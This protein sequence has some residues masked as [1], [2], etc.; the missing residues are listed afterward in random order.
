MKGSNFP[1]ADVLLYK[2]G[3]V[4]LAVSTAKARQAFKSET[5]ILD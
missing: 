5:F 4:A 1:P 2:F 3:R